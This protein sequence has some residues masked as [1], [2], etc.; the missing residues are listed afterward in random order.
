MSHLNAFEVCSFY[1]DIDIN[2]VLYIYIYT[3]IGHEDSEKRAAS[4]S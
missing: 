3:G 1:S 2:S 4:N